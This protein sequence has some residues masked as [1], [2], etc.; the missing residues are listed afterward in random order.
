[1]FSAEFLMTSLVVVLIP[2]TGV[3]SL[4]GPPDR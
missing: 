2:R 1:M 4:S 3:V